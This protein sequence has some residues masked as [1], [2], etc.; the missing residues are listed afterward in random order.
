MW[1]KSKVIE[2]ISSDGSDGE[3]SNQEEDNV[4]VSTSTA[5]YI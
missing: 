5:K 1:K 4:S 3:C 2:N